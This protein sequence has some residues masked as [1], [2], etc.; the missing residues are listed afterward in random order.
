LVMEPEG[1]GVE[2]SFDDVK[3][4][5][6]Q[7]TCEA[8]NTKTQASGIGTVQDGKASCSV[9]MPNNGLPVEI[10]W[11]FSRFACTGSQDCYAGRFKSL[12][13]VHR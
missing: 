1:D 2:I 10:V 7:L 3:P 6:N 5:P 9:I 11:H 12:R 13:S 4:M 8:R